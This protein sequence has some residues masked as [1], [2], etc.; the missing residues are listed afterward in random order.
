MRKRKI[1][2]LIPLALLLFSGIY[3]LAHKLQTKEDTSIPNIE[4]QAEEH[5]PE[6]EPIP[7]PI[8]QQI[9]AKM[10]I[11]EKV[12]QLFIFGIEG[13]ITIDPQNK[14]FLSNTK[15]GGIVLFSKNIT[16]E[17][18]LKNL[19]TEIQSTNP[20]IPLFI[21]I[22]QEGG[23]VSRLKWN[24][25]LTKSQPS[26]S[27]P[28]QAYELAKS[29]GEILK[30]LGINMNLAPVAE[31]T[32]KPSSFMY[33]RTYRGSMEDV[34]QK[35]IA[36]SKG[37]TDSEVLAVLKHFPGHGDTNTDPHKRLPSI[38]I[39]E[40]QWNSHIE[41]FSKAIQNGEIN[42]LMT[43]HILFPNISAEPT[44]ISTEIITNR[45]IEELGYKGLIISDD[46]EMNALKG[47]DTP[48]NLAKRA[49]ASGV[50]ML[51]YVK[52]TN[53]DRYSQ[54]VA[55]NSILNEVKEGR[56]NIDEQVLKILRTKLKYKVLPE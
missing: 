41:P 55:Y 35:V 21:S 1:L 52:Y 18:Q 47:V 44:T 17:N 7:I 10:S 24:E 5:I 39:T 38:N 13:N 16:N 8:E 9:L 31:I 15:P 53:D 43:G 51:I 6:P 26:I 22:D 3:L 40:E 37:Y 34:V 48:S 45:L 28:Q 11:E 36:S 42:A 32:Q 2:L 12:G 29:R 56:M 4:K 14:E 49:I 19:I 46:M 27:S 50:D 25:T 33:Q 54:R 23:V 30:N 20:T